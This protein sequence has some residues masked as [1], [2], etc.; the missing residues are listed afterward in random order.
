MLLVVVV[1]AAERRLGTRR[2]VGLLVLCQIAGC[3]I[4]I[5]GIELRSAAGDLWMQ[6]TV[7]QAGMTPTIGV[8]GLG[9]AFRSERPGPSPPFP[10]SDNHSLDRRTRSRTNRH[11]TVSARVSR[12]G[13][14]M[15]RMRRMPISR[16]RE[17]RPPLLPS[18]APIIM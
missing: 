13:D 11:V 4:A 12:I 17:A 8:T 18:P 16:Q 1:A 9:L 3:A 14:R 2:T 15:V 7:G 5:G 10:Q 6:L